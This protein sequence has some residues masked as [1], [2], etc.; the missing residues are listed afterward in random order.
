MAA[1]SLPSRKHACHL[2]EDGTCSLSP[3]VCMHQVPRRPSTKCHR[4]RLGPVGAAVGSRPGRVHTAACG[5][6]EGQ[7]GGGM[8]LPTLA[9]GPLMPPN[10]SGAGMGGGRGR[11]L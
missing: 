1:H 9:T 10:E 7:G 5:T 6:L 3:E 2:H 8:V 4:L 11:A